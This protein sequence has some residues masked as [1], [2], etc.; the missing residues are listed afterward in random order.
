MEQ[1]LLLTTA[2]LAANPRLV[3]EF[4]CLKEHFKCTVI[5]F[6]H[7]DWSAPLSQKIIAANP[8]V[9]FVQIDRKNELFST[10]W[11]KVLH[12]I[13]IRLNPFFKSSLRIAAFASNDK[14]PQL[15]K[16]TMSIVDQQKFTHII[17]HNLGAFYPAI[18][19]AKKSKAKL[20]LDIE[21]FHPGE[22]PYFNAQNEPDNRQLIMKKTLK[23][24]E[25]ITYASPMIMEECLSLFENKNSIERKSTV[26]NNCFSEKEFI[27]KLN[28]SD[29][30]K[31]VWFS[32]NISLGRGLDQIIPVLRRYSDQIEL[33][34]F[35]NLYGDFAKQF[36]NELDNFITI[37]K[38]L[39]QTRLN[40]TLANYD[41]GLAIESN[42]SDYNR[43]ICLTNK[44]WAYLQS[45]LFILASNTKAQT[46]FL[47]EHKDSGLS[48]P[49]D[50]ESLSENIKYLISNIDDI[51]KNKETRFEESKKFSWEREQIKL[52][53]SIK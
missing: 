18:K 10:I 33:H 27:Y 47:K 38:P 15:S 41:I 6:S 35:G 39:Y 21:D 7:Q 28:N 9:N 48:S 2:S 11:S 43:E 30:L 53:N 23:K 25:H 34:L 37:H 5:C 12:K 29:K 42:L 19:S 17:A 44:I 31:L 45:G 13:S 32:Q 8:S 4:E 50:E 51:R 22:M 3:K 52:K 26:V 16:K 46:R 24:A 14:T 49:M 40:L 1:I 20:Q 36:K